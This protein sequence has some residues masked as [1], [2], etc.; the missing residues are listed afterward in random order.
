MIE[1]KVENRSHCR[2]E[3][4]DKGIQT[5]LKRSTCELIERRP[6]DTFEIVNIFDE[7]V[8]VVLEVSHCN[9]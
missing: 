4:H 6:V 3:L 7:Y 5:H 1:R 2:D 9:P 8:L